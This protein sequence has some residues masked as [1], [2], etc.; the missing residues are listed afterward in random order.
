MI[1][2]TVPWNVTSCLEITLGALGNFE[3]LCNLTSYSTLRSFMNSGY[4][5]ILQNTG[6][7]HYITNPNKALLWGKSLKISLNLH[8]PSNRGNLMTPEIF[9][10]SGSKKCQDTMPWLLRFFASCSPVL[11]CLRCTLLGHVGP[12]HC[13]KKTAGIRRKNI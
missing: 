3:T 6:V 2:I 5:K 7:V 11:P 10:N 9:N 13:T 4:F 8:D 1:S 12:F